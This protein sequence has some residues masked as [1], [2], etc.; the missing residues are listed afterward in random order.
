MS[1]YAKEAYSA[2]L[3]GNADAQ[4]QQSAAAQ[5]ALLHGLKGDGERER[6]S[7]RLQ[8]TNLERQ[9]HDLEGRLF[10]ALK[11][12]RVLRQG[13]HEV[14]HAPDISRGVYSQVLDV[15]AVHVAHTKLLLE[16]LAGLMELERRDRF[17]PIGREW[18]AAR[19]AIAKATG[20]T[21]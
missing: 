14:D 21:A 2:C 13:L 20:S 16:A 1:D 19:A 17:M 4:Q 3:H 12:D 15:A 11:S 18:D 9:K 6:A 8:I 7:L 5:I 10:D